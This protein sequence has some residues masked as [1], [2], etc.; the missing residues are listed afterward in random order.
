MHCEGPFINSKKKGAHQECF[1]ESALAPSRLSDCYGSLDNVRLLTLAP[2]LQGSEETIRWLRE[3]MKCVVSLGHSMSSLSTA[4]GAVDAGASLITHLFNAMLP[5]SA[6]L[7]LLNF[8]LKLGG[9][10]AQTQF[11]TYAV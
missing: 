4:E 5:V 9:G 1:I 7:F 10:V 3:E 8:R 2:E 6:K 11:K